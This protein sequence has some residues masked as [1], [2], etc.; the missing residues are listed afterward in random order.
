VVIQSGGIN[1]Y[2][3]LLT[4]HTQ[5]SDK[6]SWK[7]L[8]LRVKFEHIWSRPWNGNAMCP[9]FSDCWT[10]SLQKLPRERAP[11]RWS[12]VSIIFAASEK[13]KKF[14]SVWCLNWMNDLWWKSILSDGGIGRPDDSPGGNLL[15]TH[16]RMRCLV[17]SINVTSWRCRHVDC[18]IVTPCEGKH[19]T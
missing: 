17:V 11:N 2:L 7:L 15:K 14:S 19:K 4:I 10:L 1:K 13:K 6:V 16:K 18:T 12:S 3:H 5:M 9:S 8:I